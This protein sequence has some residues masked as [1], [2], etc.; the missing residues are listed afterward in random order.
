MNSLCLHPNCGHESDCINFNAIRSSSNLP[1]ICWFWVVPQTPWQLEPALL[2][3]LGSAHEGS[4]WEWRLPTRATT[5]E[6]PMYM[7][8]TCDMIIADPS[9]IRRR[10]Q[11]HLWKLLPY[12]NPFQD[13]QPKKT[14]SKSI[15]K[16]IIDQK[17]HWLY[18]VGSLSHFSKP[19]YIKDTALLYDFYEV[20]LVAALLEQTMHVL[21]RASHG[22]HGPRSENT[23]SQQ[24]SEQRSQ[25]NWRKCLC[26]HIC[27]FMYIHAICSLSF[28]L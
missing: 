21:R 18:M 26:C 27:I 9:C 8:M 14:W 23:L 4:P 6:L 10:C 7:L 24:V 20:L 16:K 11:P 2:G 5:G 22:R 3:G 13:E 12:P 15:Q 25:T 28:M 19:K 17:T 1:A